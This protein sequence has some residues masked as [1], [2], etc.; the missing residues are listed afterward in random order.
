M[1]VVD[2][3]LCRDE[4]HE[5]SQRRDGLHLALGCQAYRID[6]TRD[7]PVDSLQQ[8]RLLNVHVLY[9]VAR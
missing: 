3:L 9:G 7:T 2:H 1:Y 8:E 4:L 5:G 6:K